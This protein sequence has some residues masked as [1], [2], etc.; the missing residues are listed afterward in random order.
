[1]RRDA[2]RWVRAAAWL[3]AGLT[4]CVLVAMPVLLGLNASHIDA[5]RMFA[6][7]VLAVAA[8]AYAG[9][10][11]VITSRL[12]GNAIGWLLGLVSL[13]I[14]TATFAEQYALYGLVTARGSVP[15]ARL[16]GVVAA[17]TAAHVCASNSLSA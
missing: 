13:S 8:V 5:G 6:V 3:L 9:A 14:A 16:A 7:A 17:S 10:G 2:R 4:A 15:A 12:P 11:R 1:M